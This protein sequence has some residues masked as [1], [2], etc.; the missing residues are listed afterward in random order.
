M[1]EYEL[2]SDCL[3][4]IA[5]FDPDRKLVSAA[6]AC[7]LDMSSAKQEAVVRLAD[8][9]FYG[10]RLLGLYASIVILEAA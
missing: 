6:E 4:Q 7:L 10:P 1:D 8:G 2:F 9:S 5:A 3:R